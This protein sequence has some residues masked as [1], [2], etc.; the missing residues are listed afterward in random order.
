MLC[1]T[2]YYLKSFLP[3]VINLWNN[4]PDDIRLNQSK[5]GFKTY[6]SQNINKIPLHFHLGCRRELICLAKLRLQSRVLR[7]HLFKKKS[8]IAECIFFFQTSDG[9][10][11]QHENLDIVMFS[12]KE[13][14]LFSKQKKV[15]IYW[16]SYHIFPNLYSSK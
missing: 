13:K 9:Y 7:D 8:K 16:H 11:F 10:T 1:R 3:A 2:S 6:L 15:S 4:I 5:S 12:F 14:T